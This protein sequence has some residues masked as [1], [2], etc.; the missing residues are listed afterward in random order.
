MRTSRVQ[1]NTGGKQRNRYSS[2]KWVALPFRF[3][4]PEMAAPPSRQVNI[5]VPRAEI[6]K[7]A[8]AIFISISCQ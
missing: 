6:F 1:V 4:S 5:V 3:Q 2:D 7:V 8:T